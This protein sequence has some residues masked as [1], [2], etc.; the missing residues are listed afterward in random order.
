[1]EYTSIAPM[2]NEEESHHLGSHH[3]LAPSRLQSLM[4]INSAH[5]AINHSSLMDTRRHHGALMAP[6]EEHQTFP[7]LDDPDS[8][9]GPQRKR[10][11]RDEKLPLAT[12]GQHEATL[13]VV[14]LE[15]T[16]RRAIKISGCA[17]KPNRYITGSVRCPKS[18][19]AMQHSTEQGFGT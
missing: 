4:D 2:A 8:Q 10:R 13:D 14:T 11:A 16:G 9:G 1:M 19:E 17:P 7:L 6:G 3:I 15:Y 5:M 12:E 18:P